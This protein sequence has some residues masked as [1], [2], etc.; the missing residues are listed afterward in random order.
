MPPPPVAKPM[1]SR[2]ARHIDADDPVVLVGPTTIGS[3][4]FANTYI[5]CFGRRLEIPETSA[6][7]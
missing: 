3:V 2:Q 7:R 6:T 1:C 5:S 4:K